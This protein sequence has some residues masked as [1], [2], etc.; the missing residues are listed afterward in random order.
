MCA[1][2]AKKAGYAIGYRVI[3]LSRDGFMAMAHFMVPMTG[4]VTTADPDTVMA[5]LFWACGG[6]ANPISQFR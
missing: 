2:S 5:G 1:S 4:R 6:N 3:A